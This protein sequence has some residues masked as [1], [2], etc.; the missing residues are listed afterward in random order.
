MSAVGTV[1]CPILVGRDD[2]LAHADSLI[3]EVLQGHGRAVFYSGQAGLG[4]TRLIRSIVRKAETVGFRFLGGAVAPQD[5]DVPLG[6]I[7]DLAVSNRAD[8]ELGALCVDLLAIDMHHEGDSLGARRLL[9]RAIADRILEAMDRPTVLRFADIHWADEMSLEVIGE[10]ARRASGKPLLLIAEYRGDELPTSTIHREWRARLLSQRFAE[11]VRL[12]RLTLEET[13]IATTLILGGELPAPSDVVEAVFQ[14]TNGIPFHIEE[15]LAVLAPEDRTEGRRILDAHVPDTIG[16]VIRARLGR[17]SED[18]QAVARAGA[19]LGR[20]FSPDVM[21]EVVGRPLDEIEPA[22]AELQDASFLFPFDYID[23]GYFDYPHQLLRDAIYAATPQS[24]LRRYHAQAAE[25]VMTLEASSIVHVSRH[26]DRAGLRPQAYAS[27]LTA[28]KEADRISARQ[29]AFELYERAIANMPAD[30]AAEEQAELFDRFAEAASALERNEQAEQS[31]R[32]ARALYL[33]AGRPLAA[34]RSLM[35][36]AH[37]GAR[38]GR[39]TSELRSALDAALGEVLA[40][41]ATPEREQLRAL[42]LVW[43]ADER[44]VSSEL[45]AARE[46][47]DQAQELAAALGDRELALECDLLGARI[48]IVAGRYE[49]G[50]RDGLQAARQARDAGFEWVGVTGF[51][52]LGMHAARVLDHRTAELAIAEGLLYADSIE[53]SHCRQMMASTTAL[54]DWAAGRWDV[55]N[56]RARHE[57]A[58][59]GCTRGVIDSK[60]VVGLIAMGRGRSA[61]ARHWLDDA[62]AAAERIGEVQFTL[63]PMWGLAE[64][65]LLAGDPD[66]AAARCADA[67]EIASQTGERALFIPFVVTG[68]RSLLAARKP[69]VAER[70]L[71]RARQHLAGWDSVAGPALSHAEGLL[72]LASGSFSTAREALERAVRGWEERGREWE[73]L[74][75]RLDLA[76]CLV[77]MNRPAD[78][79]DAVAE[80]Q[81]RAEVLGSEPLLVR[82]GGLAKANRRRGLEDEPWR[83]LTARE[84]EVAR[85]IAAGMTNAEIAGELFVAPRTVSAHVEH[86]LTKLGVARRAEIAAWVATIRPVDRPTTSAAATAPAAT[87]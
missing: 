18:A 23:Q 65:E 82:A 66:A 72:K 67:W 44:L 58:D 38:A 7:R 21:A 8:R 79:A 20:C 13:G 28:A 76:S 60:G 78:A 56:E 39:P 31:N 70:W 53:Q 37:S 19:V 55:A 49:S 36:I 68:L 59:R 74:W 73:A 87:N 26:Y 32:R 75:A 85:A 48:D 10:L 22:F 42:I 61:E 14:R 40:Q 11:E 77:R 2:L 24:E 45:V 46:L 35:W 4:K 5:Q 51:R 47:A 57:L 3:A 41:P 63:T 25:F 54:L 83:P 17:L 62:L 29:E 33:E 86:I 69:D 34:I 12:R 30:L 1:Q 43:A 16:D 81:R 50:F 52:N 27:S 9:I 80:V 6:V 84:F 71:V 64:A 15:L